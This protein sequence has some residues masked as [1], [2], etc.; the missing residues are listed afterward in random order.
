MTMRARIEE[1][2]SAGLE[3]I[4]YALE[5]E[6]HRHSGPGAETHWNLVVVSAAFDGK[7]RLARHRAVYAA[8]GQELK[9]GIHA[10]T[11]KTMTP[12]EWEEAGGD[13]VNPSPKCMGGSKK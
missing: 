3:P 1:N 10:L 7:N 4:H 5:N 8:L 12:S 13:V 9:D 11:L 6:S 2:I